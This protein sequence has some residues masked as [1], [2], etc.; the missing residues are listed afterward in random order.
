VPAPAPA[1]L[2]TSRQNQ[3]ATEYQRE[4]Q[5]IGSEVVVDL[6]DSPSTFSREQGN[7]QQ[8]GEGLGALGSRTTQ[9]QQLQGI[10]LHD[11]NTMGQQGWQHLQTRF[12]QSQVLQEQQR[13]VVVHQQEHSEQVR[14]DSKRKAAESPFQE[15]MVLHF[16]GLVADW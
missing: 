16:V 9:K 11:G 6:L 8:H 5:G 7:E 15:G 12:G 2:W 10:S 1:A 4:K 3:N 13:S 14:R